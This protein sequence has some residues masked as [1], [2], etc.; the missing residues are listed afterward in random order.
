[1]GLWEE[2]E[3]GREITDIRTGEVGG[4]LGSGGI[5]LTTCTGLNTLRDTRRKVVHAINYWSSHSLCTTSSSLNQLQSLLNNVS[6]L[7]EC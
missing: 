1:M 4:D 5:T 3:G 7:E 6:F 2:T